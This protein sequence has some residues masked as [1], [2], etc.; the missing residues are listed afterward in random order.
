MS[1]EIMEIREDRLLEYAKIPIAFEVKSV[2]QIDLINNGISGMSLTEKEVVTLYMKDYDSYEDGSPE[3]WVNLF[4][5]RN[6]GIFL[7]IDNNK[8]IG[9][10]TIAFNTPE[11]RMLD[12]RKDL[13]V[14]WDIRVRPEYRH[15]GI[16]TMLFKYNDASSHRPCH[17]QGRPNVQ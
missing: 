12:G 13:T 8:A 7:A 16:G 6:W 14:L 4:N 3:N 10:A 15:Q 2:Y 17:S 11:I 9:G 5:M 1:I